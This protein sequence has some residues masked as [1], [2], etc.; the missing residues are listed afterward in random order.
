MNQ[1]V[2]VLIAMDHVEVTFTLDT[3]DEGKI[4][5]AIA[6]DAN[7]DG[8]LSPEEQSA[9]FAQLDARLREGLVVSVDDRTIPLRPAGEVSLSPPAQKVFRFE[10]DLDP[11]TDFPAQ[12]LIRN[13]NFLDWPGT[14]SLKVE[15]GAGLIIKFLITST[16][17]AAGHVR[18]PSQ[19]EFRYPPMMNWRQWSWIQR[20]LSPLPMT[21]AAVVFGIMANIITLAGHRYAAHKIFAAILVTASLACA[22]FV[23]V[24]RGA[25]PETPK[26]WVSEFHTFH[27]ALSHLLASYHQDGNA[28]LLESL[29]THETMSRLMAATRVVASGDEKSGTFELRSVNPL[30]TT[31]LEEPRYPLSPT[32]RV[33][34]EWKA[35]GLMRHEGH[36]HERVRDFACDYTL[37]VTDD[38]FQLVDCSEWHQLPDEPLE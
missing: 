27:L 9:Y 21:V 3:N 33:H 34:H 37:R 12:F 4:I 6:M 11:V 38:G 19:P 28:K 25:P 17:A 30:D 36:P 8:K 5:E 22:C 35:V 1:D 24:R 2:H 16:T 10:G 31:I 26:V 32:L 15:P 23:F 14:T 7:G 29:G 13:D 18:L 20:V